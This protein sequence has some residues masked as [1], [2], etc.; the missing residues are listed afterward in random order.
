MWHP[1]MGGL[2]SEENTGLQASYLCTRLAFVPSLRF[3]QRWP[4]PPSGSV[5]PLTLPFPPSDRSLR[6]IRRS[7]FRELP[8]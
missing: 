8:D 2:W 5:T 1:G 3:W 7:N 6:Q 4:S